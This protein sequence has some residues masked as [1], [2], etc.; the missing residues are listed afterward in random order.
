MVVDLL[1]TTSSPHCSSNLLY[2]LHMY[3]WYINLVQSVQSSAYFIDLTLLHRAS[4]LL[5]LTLTL[6]FL[7]WNWRT[8][9]KITENSDAKARPPCRHHWP[10]PT[11]S[12]IFLWRE[13]QISL[14]IPLIISM[15]QPCGCRILMRIRLQRTTAIGQFR[16]FFPA[17]TQLWFRSTSDN[18][19]FVY[20]INH[21]RYPSTSVK[22]T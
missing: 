20:E 21:L 5:C 9:L 7:V 22:H 18:S 13:I 2:L 10:Y 19:R 17:G 15:R 4:W 11:R 14:L 12:F 1:L 16:T 3:H 6:L 8:L